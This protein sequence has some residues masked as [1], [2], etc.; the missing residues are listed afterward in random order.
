[1][2]SLP[3]PPTDEELKSASGIKKTDSGYGGTVYA[4]LKF[5]DFEKASKTGGMK[6][7]PAFSD[8]DSLDVSCQDDD[9]DEQKQDRNGD[10]KIEGKEKT[11]PLFHTLH[12]NVNRPES[13]LERRISHRD[14]TRNL[15]PEDDDDSTHSIDVQPSVL[16]RRQPSSSGMV[17]FPYDPQSKETLERLSVEHTS[18]MQLKRLINKELNKIS[19]DA[20][21]RIQHLNGGLSYPAFLKDILFDD[22][23]Y[24]FNNGHLRFS[25]VVFHNLQ[26]VI[27]D[28]V[29]GPGRARTFGVKAPQK[30]P[31]LSGR[32]YL[33]NHRLILISAEKQRG[34]SVASK[35]TRSSSYYLKA[36]NR[37]TLD[38]MSIPLT[39]IRGMELHASLGYSASANIS[40]RNVF[41]GLLDCCESMLPGESSCTK[42]FT[43][44]RTSHG[45]NNRTLTLG[46]MLPPWLHPTN[47]CIHAS[48]EVGMR[49]IRDFMV[50]LQ[51]ITPALRTYPQRPS[52]EN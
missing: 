38:F 22:E 35:G 20:D 26:E 11:N 17:V 37:D 27:S 4:D 24:M 29:Q 14:S 18:H 25:S 34:A 6:L 39:N 45:S 46:V 31:F 10:V 3:L 36:L 50:E 30:P 51:H 12:R 47:V 28:S 32:A 43:S 7:G 2:M 23:L 5:E 44:D 52:N 16:I 48:Q 19:R 49:T 9:E 1:M 15:L 8:L 41:F 33:T 40:S 21:V 42:W 13:D